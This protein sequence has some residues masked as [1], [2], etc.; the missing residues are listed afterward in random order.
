MFNELLQRSSRMI[1][2]VGRRFDGL[3]FQVIGYWARERSQES[4]SSVSSTATAVIK[5]TW[6]TP[7]YRGGRSVC[8]RRNS[9]TPY[10]GPR[11][12][13]R[14][15]AKSYGQRFGWVR[16]LP[17]ISER[18]T[19]AFKATACVLWEKCTQCCVAEPVV[20]CIRISLY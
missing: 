18:A 9:S 3:W 2:T 5:P 1:T 16:V 6:F 10:R 20:E 14:T 17:L 8:R 12:I 13:A 11:K 7:G 19:A 4:K 15:R